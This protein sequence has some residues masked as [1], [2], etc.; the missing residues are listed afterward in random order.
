M[1][2]KDF[3]KIIVESTKEVIESFGKLKEVES[4]FFEL[5]GNYD[6]LI[7]SSNFDRY[8]YL[9]FKAI[10]KHFVKIEDR[11]EITKEIGKKVYAFVKGKINL[12]LKDV[13]E[14]LNKIINYLKESGY[15]KS[16]KIDWSS[17]SDGSFLYIMGEPVILPGAQRLFKEEGFAQ[18]YSSR[19]MEAALL[20]L[21]FIGRETK[22]FD[23][24]KY[25]SDKVVE[26]WELKKIN[27]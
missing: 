22:D 26:K 25:P 12:E 20:D 9:F 17:F 27:L 4:S 7:D 3:V 10:S 15:V 21:D 5:G 16:A 8:S 24:T 1:L 18:H 6:N 14:N 19:I 23:P 11:D 13:K 2:S